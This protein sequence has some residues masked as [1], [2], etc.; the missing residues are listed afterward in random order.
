MRQG[1]KASEQTASAGRMHY[2]WVVLG[3][4]VVIMITAG[5]LRASFGV[6]I[7]PMEAEFG[8]S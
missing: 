4:L 6:F 8:W 1:R 5:G 7:K 2:A 3:V